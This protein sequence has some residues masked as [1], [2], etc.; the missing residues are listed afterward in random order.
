MSILIRDLRPDD[1][2]DLTVASRVRHAAL[3]SMVSTP[4]GLAFEL[5]SA[6]PA[7]RQRILVA[8][9]A[10]QVVGIAEAGLAYDSPEPGQASLNTFVD[11]AHRGRGA[12]TALARAG[13][14]HLAGAGGTRV[15]TWVLDEP[16]CTGF[17]ARRGYAPRRR[18]HFLRLDLS[19]G[20]LPERVPLPPGV[21]L[22]PA[23]AFADD[24]RPLYEADADATADEP[25]DVPV[26]LSDYED[27]LRT[28]WHDPTLDRELTMVALVDGA[29]AAFSAARTDGAD[30]YGSAMTGTR[31]A[32]RGRGL[33]KLVKNASLHRARAAG[34][35]E[36]F[37]GNDA[38]NGPMLAVNKWFGYEICATEVRYVKTLTTPEVSR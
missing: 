18:A 34:Y 38:Q 10:G 20:P 8:E 24:P 2:A 17:A 35:R 5:A 6:N 21:E 1:D 12:G 19:A 30:R 27:W 31:R 28:V 9:E 33:A 29:V 7:A 26:E 3:P 15:Y 25:G 22:L 14:E 4:A 37:T 16:A 32:Y 36:A 13:E 23:A 11:P